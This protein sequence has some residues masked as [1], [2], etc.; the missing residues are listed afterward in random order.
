MDK[1]AFLCIEVLFKSYRNM[2][3]ASKRGDVCLIET[4]H[5]NET[6][7]FTINWQMGEHTETVSAIMIYLK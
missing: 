1:M 5:I 7:I 2:Q 4:T 3:L 6:A